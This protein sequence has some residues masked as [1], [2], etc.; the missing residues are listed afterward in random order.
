MNIRQR[1]G[2]VNI[3]DTHRIA[4]FRLARYA[5]CSW[6][7]RHP[8]TREKTV[9]RKY[10]QKARAEQQA[11]T[12][13]RIVEAAVALHQEVGGEAATISLI[14][15]RAGVGRPTVY[16]HF[17]DERA[18][19]T[20]CTGHYLTLNPPPNPEMWLALTDP[21]DRLRNA[22][23]AAYDYYG[24]THVMLARA[25]QE[26]PTN[27]VLA[28]LMAPFG[29]FWAY[30]RDSVAQGFASNRK[31]DPLIPAA[32]GHAVAF[33]T[34]RSLVQNQ[35]LSNDQATSLMVR[36]VRCVVTAEQN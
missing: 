32:I 23:E 31:V 10:D 24:R 20:A 9:P 26:T 16:R 33:S 36:M 17:P 22:I 11:E 21:F 15:Q 27:P 8:D 3:R 7:Q 13:Q 14:A 30:V 4:I 34:W 25:E 5:M 6:L 2:V 29:A 12:H 19:L 1:E 35:G 28:D 18:L